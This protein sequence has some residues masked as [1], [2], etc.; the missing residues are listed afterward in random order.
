MAYL[1][2]VVMAPIGTPEK[3]RILNWQQILSN[4]FDIEMDAATLAQMLP[5]LDSQLQSG[6]LDR[7]QNRMASRGELSIESIQ[8]GVAE[9]I[10]DIAK[11]AVGAVKKAG[12]KALDTLGHG[13]DEDMIKDLQKK[14][15]M[16]QTGKKPMATKNESSTARGRRIAEAAIRK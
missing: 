10:K 14:T 12:S 4:Q 15:G 11:K 1:K 8:R 2:A 7:L 5:Q 9:G 16:P 3:R 13:S 6:K